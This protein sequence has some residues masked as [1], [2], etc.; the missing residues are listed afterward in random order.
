MRDLQSDMSSMS[1]V[2]LLATIRRLAVKE[3]STSAHRMRLSKMTQAPGT[4]IRTFSASLKGQA[5]LY[6]HAARCR[7][8]GCEH[9]Y[10]Y[11]AEIIRDNL[12]RSIADPEILNDILG[13]PKTDKTLEETVNLIA[14]KEQG[15]ASRS[16]V[17]N[18]A[19][20][21]SQTTYTSC[22]KTQ[23]SNSN[24]QRE[25]WT[26]GKLG[27]CGD[28]NTRKKVCSARSSSCRICSV[29]G[30]YTSCCGKCSSCNQY[31]HRNKNSRWCT[32]LQKGTNRIQEQH[33]ETLQ[34]EDDTTTL[35]DQL[36]AVETTHNNEVKKIGR[37]PC[38]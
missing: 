35:Y 30:N 4:P 9:T 23:P 13:D 6:Q 33:S 17:G 12:I 18:T 31:G 37:T 15:N 22:H 29:T 32:E 2:E 36:C 28:H 26:C 19:A 10:D 21:M 25:C 7:E 8:P 14:Q 11:S 24:D 27:H 38:V 34:T 1:E 20:S 5:S 3:E 16:A